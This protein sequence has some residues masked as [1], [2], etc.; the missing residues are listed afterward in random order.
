MC[1]VS[2]V[3]KYI[4]IGIIDNSYLISALEANSNKHK[5]IGDILIQVQRMTF[6]IYYRTFFD[7]I[8]LIS[9]VSKS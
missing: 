8:V 3:V 4:M 9:L 2:L 7:E 1:Q 5:F 6:C